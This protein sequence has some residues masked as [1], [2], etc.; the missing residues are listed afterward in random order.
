M[1][2][3][4][5]QAAGGSNCCLFYWKLHNFLVLLAG[6]KELTMVDR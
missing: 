5:S 6:A 3:G 1:Q 2:F 4:T